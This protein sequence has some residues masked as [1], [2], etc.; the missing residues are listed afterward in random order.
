M[1]DKPA[2]DVS[3]DPARC[4]ACGRSFYEEPA[5]YQCPRCATSMEIDP[6]AK[7]R[8]LPPEQTGEREEMVERLNKDVNDLNNL[9]RAAGWGQGEIDSAACV[10]EKA[11]SEVER[12]VERYSHSLNDGLMKSKMYNEMLER[13]EAAESALCE[14]RERVIEECAKAAEQ[15]PF[16]H[17]NGVPVFPSDCARAIRA[18][19]DKP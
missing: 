7:P 19:K 18:L 2:R 1:T 9:L 12:V 17:K 5:V 8:S 11:E 4:R 16:V 3:D 10:I 14:A 6:T 13:A 15:Q